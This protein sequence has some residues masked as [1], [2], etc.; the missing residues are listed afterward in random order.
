MNNADPGPVWILFGSSE[1]TTEMNFKVRISFSLTQR[2][3]AAPESQ[4]MPFAALQSTMCSSFGLL[5][6][7][8]EHC[9]IFKD[10]ELLALKQN[11]HRL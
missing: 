3:I 8:R 5:F 1:A 7:A 10:R 4:E 6:A 9:G 2:K 11:P